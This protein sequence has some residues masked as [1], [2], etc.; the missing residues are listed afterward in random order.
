MKI[1]TS[2]NYTAPPNSD[3]RWVAVCEDSYDGAPDSKA[4]EMGFGKTG[5]EAARD[6]LD[7]LEDKSCVVRGV[8]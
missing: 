8:R 5:T 7:K 3:F 2:I 4:R 6:L 1:V